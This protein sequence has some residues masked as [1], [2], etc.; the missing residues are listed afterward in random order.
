MITVAPAPAQ[1]TT[2]SSGGEG[3]SDPSTSQKGGGTFLTEILNAVSTEAA[4]K[5]TN[6]DQS[7]NQIAV[8]AK[9]SIEVMAGT[10]VV[11]S[12]G[13][14]GNGQPLASKQV[15]APLVD[16]GA[17]KVIDLLVTVIP[18]TSNQ[19]PS[20]DPK[21]S[22]QLPSSHLIGVKSGSNA[23]AVAAKRA[24]SAKASSSQQAQAPVPTTTTAPNLL[25]A[26]SQFQSVQASSSVATNAEKPVQNT[27]QAIGV[28]ASVSPQ[29]IQPQA[30]VQ[31]QSKTPTSGWQTNASPVAQSPM[32]GVGQPIGLGSKD[33]PAVAPT[34]NSL[35]KVDNPTSTETGRFT[36]VGRV[37]SA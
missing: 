28:I 23:S 2:T 3:P 29:S 6:V 14:K 11:V 17:A 9:V 1:T 16:K 37:L 20:I 22:N 27:T 12:S 13:T 7:L 18:G 4:S 33:L 31:V 10:P 26:I 21:T 30:P 25:M 19:M 8:S 36:E 32:T 5:P 24:D 34:S 35:A 15:E